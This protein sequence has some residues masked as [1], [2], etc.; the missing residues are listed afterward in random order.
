MSGSMIIPFVILQIA[1]VVAIV[2]F[3]RMLLHKQLEI[4]MDRIKKMDKDNLEKE[5]LLNEK[6]DKLRKEY[7][8]KIKEAERQADLMLSLAKDDV[9]KMRD[10]E[11]EKAKDESKKIIA[12][13]NKEKEKVLNETKSE[14]Y[15]KAVE[16]SVKIL[17]RILSDED[18]SA[19][20]RKTAKDA[21]SAVLDMPEIK[22]LLDKHREAEIITA[23][24]L[25]EEDKTH[26]AEA[27]KAISLGKADV[28][29]S[30][31]KNALGGLLIKIGASTID[32]TLIARVAVTAKEMKG[33]G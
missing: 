22:E 18:L 19:L 15:R 8:S 7:E 12:G 11:R 21:I 24:D 23:D 17:R 29:F 13:A 5:V 20:R 14:I 25:P 3:L 27:V 9:K 28:K 6:L 2:M 32:A 10:E 30:R 33:E 16:F 1:T 26:I 4:G 31:D